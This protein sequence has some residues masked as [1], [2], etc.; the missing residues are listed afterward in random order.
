MCLSAQVHLLSPTVKFTLE[1]NIY[2]S[3]VEG[4]IGKGVKGLPESVNTRTGL[5]E[6]LAILSTPHLF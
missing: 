2:Q 5:T 6:L 1:R 4:E 3:V